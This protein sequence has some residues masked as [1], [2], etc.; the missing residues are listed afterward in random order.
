M[1]ASP[2]HAALEAGILA[3]RYI[4]FLVMEFI[5]RNDAARWARAQ[6]ACLTVPR[7]SMP[8]CTVCR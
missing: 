6:A 8:T 4:D 5:G 3:G 2:F 7:G 1:I